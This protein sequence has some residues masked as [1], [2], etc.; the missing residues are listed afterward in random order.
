MNIRNLVTSRLPEITTYDSGGNVTG[1]V[2]GNVTATA[3][4]RGAQVIST[5]TMVGLNDIVVGNIA[6]AAATKTR[7]T[8]FGAN[9]FIQTGNGTVGTTGNVVFSTFGDDIARV[10]V[11]TTSGNVSAAGNV[12]AN[13]FIGNGSQLTG[14]S[15]AEPNW[16]NAGTIQ[17]VGVG[18]TSIAPIISTTGV[19]K[20]SVLYKQLG[21]KTWQIMVNY[22]LT[23]GGSGAGTGNGDYL[24]TLPLGLQFDTTLP[25]QSAYQAAVLTNS[26]DILSRSIPNSAAYAQDG[27]TFAGWN[28]AVSGPVVWDATRYRVM[29]PTSTDFRCLG[30]SWFAFSTFPIRIVYWTFTFQSL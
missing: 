8:S 5:G 1:I 19:T 24:F 22:E 21:P 3:N 4:I 25:N 6:N 20:N 14:I 26:T 7:I 30:N 11:N 2:V 9:S 10:V 17:A 13:F 27:V 29:V 23:G 12:S 15:A 16:T 28:V 18:A